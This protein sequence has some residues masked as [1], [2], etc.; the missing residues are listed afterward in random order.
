MECSPV[1]PHPQEKPPQRN[2]IY[3]DIFV[4]P[5]NPEIRILCLLPG[6]YGKEI[7][8]N[9]VRKSL[10]DY[11]SVESDR[12]LR[13]HYFESE[14]CGY[15]ALSYTWGCHSDKVVTLNGPPGFAVTDNLF[16]ALQRLRKTEEAVWLWIDAICINQNDLDERA[17][18]I[19]LMGRIYNRARKVLI[20]LGDADEPETVTEQTYKWTFGWSAPVSAFQDW[21]LR[22]LAA[23]IRNTRP[24][25]W[26]RAWVLQ[27]TVL[28]YWDP[29]ICFGT[30]T[31]TVSEFNWMSSLIED[32]G[33]TQTAIFLR[34]REDLRRTPFMERKLDQT[35]TRSITEYAKRLCRLD[36]TD[37]RDK[38]YSV[39]GV[40]HPTEQEKI[41]IDYTKEIWKVYAN[42]TGAAI[43]A[44]QI[45]E[46][47]AFVTVDR[48]RAA[49]LPSWAV[50]FTFGRHI[51]QSKTD[52]EYMSDRMFY[53]EDNDWAKKL[54]FEPRDV[55]AAHAEELDTL[56]VHGVHFDTI[57][58]VIPIFEGDN[59]F[60]ISLDVEGWSPETSSTI[61]KVLSN[62][63]AM[64]P[65]RCLDCFSIPPVWYSKRYPFNTPVAWYANQ[66]S[67]S[68]D[69][70]KLI[71]KAK[72]PAFGQLED[73]FT[74]WHSGCAFNSAPQS[75]DYSARRFPD[76][77][78]KYARFVGGDLAIF[79]T[80]AGFI[81]FA[82]GVI[83]TGDAIVLLA[84][85]TLPAI[86][87]RKDDLRYTWRCYAFLEGIM[88][89]ELLELLSD[90]EYLEDDFTLM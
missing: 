59:F 86:I 18:Q 82:P 25:W 38:V 9:L 73:V 21:Q 36:A 62:I 72:T 26:T 61:A 67:Y 55:N 1:Q 28:A 35:W 63:P 50:D 46:L 6:K 31:M 4:D 20:W 5:E 69:W 37:P 87:R 27:E 84:G 22:S 85:A 44:N 51:S 80:A 16:V 74:M 42:A 41:V 79:T 40:I 90:A 11:E 58:K 13:L 48:W 47:L 66:E 34:V 76:D 33:P 10:L 23:A 17:R 54:R 65:Y 52:F 29:P 68:V 88:N 7:C 83:Q 71:A 32:E 70:K 81:G 49:N 8:C 53:F 60:G 24:S 57:E 77:W 39:L 45:L 89:D 78:K 75:F 14:K 19:R 12:A 64:D 3:P 2:T 30:F 56:T 43:T 15:D